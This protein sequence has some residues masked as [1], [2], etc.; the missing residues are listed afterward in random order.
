MKHTVLYI[1]GKGG[2]AREA[3]RY[4]ALCPEYQVVG[5]DD[6]GELP[7]E[8]RGQLQA[9]CAKARRQS[10]HVIVL[11]NSIGAYF[12]M[13]ALQGCPLAKALFIS[14]VL[15]MERLIL[16]M[17]GWAGV[18]E[19]ELQERGEIPTAFGETL[20]WR[21]LC[22]VREHPVAWDVPTEIL[23]AGNDHLTARQTVDAFVRS[24]CAR[25]TV[26]E[27]GE[28][29]FHTEQQLAFLDGWIKEVLR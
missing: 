18:S 5:V 24:H 6:Q 28:H 26:M 9:A 3:E 13:D 12:A 8:V 19:A 27:D 4:R 16:D 25:L 7:W 21:Y 14:P 23:Y 11:A 17:M 20:S 29:W 15:D 22:Y 10:E 1:H 2:S